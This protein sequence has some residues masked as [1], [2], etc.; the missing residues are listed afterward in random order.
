[1]RSDKLYIIQILESNKNF[2]EKYELIYKILIKKVQDKNSE[3]NLDVKYLKRLIDELIRHN[4]IRKFITIDNKYLMFS[5]EYNEKKN[6]ILYDQ[7][8]LIEKLSKENVKSLY[9]LDKVDNNKYIKKNKTSETSQPENLYILDYN[10]GYNFDKLRLDFTIKDEIKLEKE[11]DKKQQKCPRGTRYN[12]QLEK[13]I[14]IE[15]N[16]EEEKVKLKKKF[17]KKEAEKI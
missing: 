6:Q 12:K 5:S 9:N 16:A 8:T 7:G 14:P 17:L 3:N 11:E 2:Q 4:Q 10:D 1:M 13:C 15:I